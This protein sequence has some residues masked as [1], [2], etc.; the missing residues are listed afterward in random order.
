M[1]TLRPYQTQ[2]AELIVKTDALIADACGLGKTVEAIEGAKLFRGGPLWRALVI[3]PLRLRDQWIDEIKEQDPDH[4]VVVWDHGVIPEKPLDWVVTHYEY[5]TEYYS[6][7]NFVWDIIIVD[8]AHRIKGRKTKRAKAIK[9]LH[10]A[11]KVALTG[12]PME[13]SAGDLWSILNWLNPDEFRGYWAFDTKYVNRIENFYGYKVIEGNKNEEE[14]TRVINPY[15]LRRT[16]E[17]V[18]PELPPRI[19]QTIRLTM[20]DEQKKV[21]E[22]IKNAD[23]VIVDD[24]VITNALAQ[25]LRLQQITSYPMQLDYFVPSIKMQWLREWWRDNPNE[26]VIIFAKFRKTAEHIHAMWPDELDLLMGGTPL[27]ELFLS[28]G[29]RGVVGTIDAMGEGL[30]LQRADVAIFVDLHWSTIKMQQAIDRIHRI[31]I[32]GPKQIIYLICRS[33]VDNHINRALKNKWSES[34]FVYE[35]LKETE[36]G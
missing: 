5:I 16:K 13:K 31:N 29:V 32:T 22:R 24:L 36:N 7:M 15:M 23:D 19:M 18:E 12:T 4:P 8:E 33:S 11:R 2:A 3:C 10:A 20:S 27:P 14:L 1:K 26:T 28:G 34:E 30:N 25:I 21:Y 9:Q 17:E 6:L 35:Y